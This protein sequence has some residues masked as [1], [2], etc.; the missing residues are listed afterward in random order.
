[1]QWENLYYALTQLVHNFGALAVVAGAIAGLKLG[2]TRLELKRTFAWVVVTG[3]G[4][5]IVSGL[6][7][8]GISLY[9]YGETPDLHSTAQVAFVIKLVCATSGFALAVYY[10]LKAD[11][12]SAHGRHRAWHML[13]GLG[14]TAL[15]AAAFLRWF[16]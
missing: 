9:F 12:W 6:I 1:M 10:L 8:G 14:G 7:F 13:A 5:Q 11:S 16:S 3:W 2:E 15:A 4:A